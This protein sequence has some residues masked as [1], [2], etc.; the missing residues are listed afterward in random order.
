[1][2]RCD[3]TRLASW[4]TQFMGRRPFLAACATAVAGVHPMCCGAAALSPTFRFEKTGRVILARGSAGSFDSTHAKYPCVLKVSDVWMMWYNGR[5]DDAFTGSVGLASS[6]DGLTW[7]KANQGRPVFRHGGP[8]SADETK[9]DHPA[10]VYFDGRFH[11]WYTAGDEQSRYKICY[12][13]STDG[14]EWHRQNDGRPVLGPGQAGKFD[15]QVVLHPAVVRDDTGLLHIWYNGVGPQKNFQVGHATS[16]DGIEW[17]RQNDGD[18]VLTA[19]TVGG[20]R[21]IYVFNVMVLLEQDVYRM[22]YSC[23]L[24]LT[25]DEGRYAEHGCGIVYAESR[26]GTHWTRDDAITLVS[27]DVGEQDAYACF[28]P[29]IVRRADSLWMYYSMGSAWQRYQVGLAKSPDGV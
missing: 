7:T 23:A 14:I 18:P 19:G 6:S 22:W 15:D 5:A 27:G 20:R 1:M 26:D 11:M 25:A 8:G 21:E 24:A 10:V 4:S 28:A 13:T 12:A 9:V 2:E 16:R 29:Y 17:E 3:P